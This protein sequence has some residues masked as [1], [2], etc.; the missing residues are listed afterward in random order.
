MAIE[1]QSGLKDINQNYEQKYGFNEPERSLY[2]AP[3][4][5]S[6]E[7]VE[8][9]SQIKNEPQWMRE[10]RLKA[11]AQFLERPMPT[12][13][14]PFLQKVDF[15]DI[16]YFIQT[17]EHPERSWDDVPEDMKRTF[18]KLGIPE[19][20]QKWLSGAGAQYDSSSA[21][22]QLQENL[23]KQGVIFLDMDTALSEHEELVRQYWGTVIPSNDNK[24]AALNSAVW[25]GGSFVY[26]PEG[27][28]VDMPLQAYFRI[29]SERAGQ[30][31]RTMIIAEEGSYVSYVEGCLPA[32]E[33]ISL[34]DKW[35]NIESIHPGDHVIGDDGKKHKVSKTMTRNY[36]GD[37][38]KIHPYSPQNAFEVTPEH[39]ILAIPREKVQRNDR[40]PSDRKITRTDFDKLEQASP[41]YLPAGQLKHGDYLV[42]P[43]VFAQ[44]GSESEGFTPDLLRILGFYLSEGSIGA[45]ERQVSFA[46]NSNE[47]DL[48][49]TLSDS[50][51]AFLGKRP[52]MIP[53]KGKEGTVVLIGSPKL[54]QLCIKHCGRLSHKKQLSGEIMNLP[55]NLTKLLLESH[56]AG[57]GHLNL[58]HGKAEVWEICSSSQSLVYQLQELLARQG[59]YASISKRPARKSIIWGKEYDCR[60]VYVLHYAPSP[61]RRTMLK[62]D[63]H[64][65]V[66]IRKTIKRAYNGP[67]FNI[68]VEDSQSYLAKGFAVHN[69]TAPS[70]SSSSLHSAVV[71]LVAKPRA[72]IRYST[73]QNWPSGLGG[74]GGIANLVTK[75]GVAHEDAAIEWVDCNIGSRLTMKYPSIY[76]VGERAHGEIL[77]IALA[78][79]GQHQDAGGKIIHAAPHTTSNILSK[80]IS[81]EGGRATYRGLLEVAKGAHHSR[82]S[83]VCDALLLDERSRSDTYPTIRIGN[84]EVDIGHE[85][86][87]SKVGEEQLFY[88][89]SH[90][91]SELEAK[92]LIVNGFLEP[93]IKQLP[94]EYAVE[95]NRLIDLEMEGSVG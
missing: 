94:M 93:I 51:Y 87:V 25:S 32:G 42:F 52:S 6:R 50:L 66:P 55:D 62:T 43:R 92:G 37:M 40:V 46:F 80:S 9:I 64:F 44:P 27:V 71:E 53:C 91:L 33:Q 28:K 73:Y 65:L 79:N 26:I 63:T 61:R 14:S 21:Y 75:R 77:S 39:P 19:A 35:A 68:E 31:E 85:A 38:I 54:V 60:A 72:R 36:Q 22:H 89:Q 41:E 29:N 84:D 18:D 30:F 10:N 88:L 3:K 12:W 69:C 47:T 48:M 57:D 4:G 56:A 7:L 76:L 8:T 1:T 2:K 5:L 86:S 70:Y 58:H 34:G 23:E 78:G 11:L 90:G 59:V 15:D 20:E 24:L 81:R 17:T 95:M 67:V 49:E 74:E 16:Y 45:R 82:S 83:V 13:G